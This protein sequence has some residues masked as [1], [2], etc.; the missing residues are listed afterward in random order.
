MF[1]KKN[2]IIASILVIVAATLK[3][4]TF[5]NSFT[6][7]IAI[8]LFCGAVFQDKKMAFVVPVLAMLLSDVMLEFSGKATGFY[9]W[10]QL[11]NYACLL[12]VTFLGMGMKKINVLSVA[13]FS[14]ASSILFYFLS[15][16]ITFLFSN[17][18]YENSL[19]GYLL[20][21]EAGLPFLQKGILVD[22]AY[23]SVF[24]SVYYF[25]VVKEKQL[26]RAN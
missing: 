15:N 7:I 1:T 14:L 16:S 23:S 25:Y 26:A 24:F 12:F 3:V 18:Y 6:P 8:A 20:C 13:G 4:V 10:G 22:L 11:A 5:P 2:I 17:G 21:M 9:G 19:N